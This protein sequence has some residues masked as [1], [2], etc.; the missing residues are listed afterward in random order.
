MM[1][2]V[3][4]GAVTPEWKVHLTPVDRA[5]SEPN[6]GSADDGT[7]VAACLDGNRAA[8]EP[9][10]ERHRRQIYQLCYRYV[11]NH[12]DAS[13]LA[14]DVFVRAFRGLRGFKGKSS[15]STWLYRIAINVCL[16]RVSLK[17]AAL[18]PLT[19]RSAPVSDAEAADAAILR[20]QRAE[21][22]RAAIAKLPPRQR[23]TLI[24]R[25][26]HELPH[27][28]IAGVL[29]TSVGAVKANFFHALANLKK[30]L[31]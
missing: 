18:E 12:E 19:E 30:L 5:S 3:W 11:G 28:E 15:F 26:Y 8:F 16:N 21:T 22:V 29:G 1:S 25:V 31:S 27:G 7:L 17:A 4:T 10:V 6:W 14:Q 9:L 20:R 24:L 23:A 13:D 2:R